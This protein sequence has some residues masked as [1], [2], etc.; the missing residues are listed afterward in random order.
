MERNPCSWPFCWNQL[1]LLPPLSLSALC[2]AGKGMPVFLTG[3]RDW[4]SFLQGRGHEQ[5]FL[6]IGTP[7]KVKLRQSS[8]K[9]IL[10]HNRPVHLNI[11]SGADPGSDPLTFI[12]ICSTGVCAACSPKSRRYEGQWDMHD[13][14]NVS[15]VQRLLP[16]VKKL[17]GNAEQH[18]QSAEE[19]H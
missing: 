10:I 19:S 4:D 9:N 2:V 5:G 3:D 15:V 12:R 16:C 8:Y 18:Q 14:A 17:L 1:H 7:S 11:G 6:S 13:W